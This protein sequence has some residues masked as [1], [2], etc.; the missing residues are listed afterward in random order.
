MKTNKNTTE[1][2][3]QPPEGED[4]KPLKKGKKPPFD[5]NQLLDIDKLK[6]IA[7]N[8]NETQ[9]G[10]FAGTIFMLGYVLY[11]FVLMAPVQPTT[12]MSAMP[13]Q[14]GTHGETA[15][16][17]FKREN[18]DVKLP[19]GSAIPAEVIEEK[20]QLTQQVPFGDK[21]LEFRIRLSKNW[22]MSEFARY[23]L[24]GEENYAVLT[25]IA[26]YFGPTIVDTRPYVW[27][28]TERMK[29]FMSAEAWTRAY[30]IKRGISPQ[31]LQVVSSTEVQAL[32]VDVRDLQSYAV[33]ALFR[34]EGDMM[35]MVTF[36]VPVDYYN[37]YKD[38]MALS[39]NSFKL[40]RPINRVIE[41]IKDYRLL[42]VMNFKH[43]T[44]W[45]PKNEWAESTL[46]P[47]V[48]LHSP[49]ERWNEAGDKLQGLILV[50]VWRNSEQFTHESN[51]LEI[52]NRL[53]RMN[54]TLR[55]PE[56]PAEK[57]PLHAN[58]KSIER[59]EYL[60]Q[61]NSYVRTDQFDIVKSDK[62]VTYQEVWITIL[63]NGYYRA[64][65]TLI[66]PQKGTNYVT[67]AQNQAAYELLNE[68]ITVRGAPS[69]IE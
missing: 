57:L 26:R 68:S 32:Y 63:D 62:S 44:S 50:N 30:M 31:V 64:Y 56:K 13:I 12:T 49:Q 34:V 67:W 52:K 24:P 43:Y 18:K 22:F 51:I 48:E 40:L 7:S 46:R 65:L 19:D 42:N 45:L 36:G 66:T 8:M 23:G 9:W 28:E 53:L 11:E 54:M 41:D 21:E 1:P 69:D 2:T 3:P 14:S 39:L 61:V 60:A 6:E 15:E 16:E 55:D 29:R 5:F 33:R 27:V 47:F 38:I 35:I 17:K 58:F 4:G 37:D 10:M 20:T 59:T 25:N